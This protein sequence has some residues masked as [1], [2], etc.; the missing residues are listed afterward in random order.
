M[1][2]HMSLLIRACE[3]MCLQCPEEGAGIPGGRVMHSREAWCSW[4][5]NWGSL[6][7]QNML[8]TAETFT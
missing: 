3:E 2:F 4:E 1:C 6:K 8:F 5:L 7:E